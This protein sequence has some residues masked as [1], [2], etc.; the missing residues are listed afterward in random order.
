MLTASRLARPF[1]GRDY[2]LLVIAHDFFRAAAFWS[3]VGLLAWIGIGK[4]CVRVLG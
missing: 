2:L 4:L 3:M 1:G